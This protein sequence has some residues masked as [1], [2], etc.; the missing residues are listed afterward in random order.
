MDG[1][2]AAGSGPPGPLFCPECQI[3][4]PPDLQLQANP[5]L[6]AL[7]QEAGGQ[8]QGKRDWT[9]PPAPAELGHEVTALSG[10]GPTLT[11]DHC[12]ERVSV[13]VRSCV[14]C[15]AALCAAHA[16]A[17]QKRQALRTHTL[18]EPAGDLLSYRCQHHGEELR[19]FCADERLP[20]CSLCAAVGSHRGHQVIPLQEATSD[21]KVSAGRPL[22]IGLDWIR[23]FRLSLNGLH[24]TFLF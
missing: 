9:G 22:G 5:T 24:S 6:Q 14:T 17:H 13:A 16:Q 2:G 7:V 18:V 1:D 20:V 23:Y 8:N 19:L 12:I 21:L 3:L 11:C 15:D 10:E 4:L